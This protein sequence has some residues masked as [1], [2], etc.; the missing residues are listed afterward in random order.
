MLIFANKGPQQQWTEMQVDEVIMKPVSLL[1]CAFFLINDN[2]Q[3]AWPFHQLA[4]LQMHIFA[5]QG[6][7][8]R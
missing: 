4:L 8:H 7:Q 6:P 1:C 2:F 5:N 3:D